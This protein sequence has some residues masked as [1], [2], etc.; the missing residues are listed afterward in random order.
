MSNQQHPK[1]YYLRFDIHQR[2]QHILLIVSFL[3]LVATG[4]TFR[5]A[6]AP[7]TRAIAQFV[8]GA[9]VLSMIHRAT[10]ILLLATGIYHVIYLILQF[11]KGL[12]STTMLPKIKDVSDFIR[13][14]LYN[15]GLVREAPRYDRYSFDEKFEY[16]SVVW[17]TIVM[18]A[19]GVLLWN[20]VWTTQH[21]P[22]IYLLVARVIHSY[23]GLLAIL[24]IIIWHSYH[25]HLRPDVFPMSRVWLD[26]LISEEE[27]KKHHPLEY[28]RIMTRQHKEDEKT[29]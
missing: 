23:E 17:G 7:G 13:A 22:Y 26:G 9:Y 28:E 25:A 1:R 5:Y 19:T 8:G 11:A 27:M 3:T 14:V 2:I 21:L 12:R 24:A 15:F 29:D 4:L 6:G 10:A 16:W 20:P 18:A